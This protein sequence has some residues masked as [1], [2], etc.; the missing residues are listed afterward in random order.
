MAKDDKTIDDSKTQTTSLGDKTVTNS[1]SDFVQIPKSEYE[2]W[3]KSVEEM[4]KF[5][6]E[7]E[8]YLKGAS[9]VVNTLA[10]DPELTES[11]KKR[12]SGVVGDGQGT[13]QQPQQVSTQVQTNGNDG[14][15]TTDYSKDVAEVKASQREEIVSAF[16][17]DYG[18][19]GLGEDDRRDARRKI[20][21]YLNEFGWKVSTM[22]LTSLRSS[23]EKAYIGTHAEK[24]KEE[25]KLEG[26]VQ[27]RTNQSGMM[28]SF[29]SGTLET[30]QE[31]DLTPKQKEW[32]EKLGVDSEKAKKTFVSRDDEEKRLSGA[33]KRLQE[34]P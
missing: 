28:G 15:K 7:T 18:I 30:S 4:N 32:A 34:K 11:F 9:V 2:G 8:D 16:E 14:S 6:T 19:V 33:E 24:L 5:R 21:G 20:E 26:F 3:K 22:P 31:A 13:S 23:M 27:A 10:S 29:P 12:L 1:D 17:K 25:G